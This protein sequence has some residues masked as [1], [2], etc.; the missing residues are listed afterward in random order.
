MTAVNFQASYVF[1]PGTNDRLLATAHEGGQV[2]LHS[3]TFS[4]AD[5]AVRLL[6]EHIPT[7]EKIL[8][9]L[10]KERNRRD[11]VVEPT[12]GAVPC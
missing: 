2:S 9:L 8:F 11:E 3:A 4:G 10:I 12:T 5:F 7:V 1:D 6:P